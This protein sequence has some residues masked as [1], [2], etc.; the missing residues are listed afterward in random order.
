[1]NKMQA[2]KELQRV[3]KEDLEKIIYMIEESK[4]DYNSLDDFKL[5][6]FEE[7]ENMQEYIKDFFFHNYYIYIDYVSGKLYFRE[8]NP[9]VPLDKIFRRLD[10]ETTKT[11]LQ[12][13]QELKE[14]IKKEEIKQNKKLDDY[15]KKL[16]EEFEGSKTMTKKTYTPK[17]IT[18]MWADNDNQFL[19]IEFNNA[20]ILRVNYRDLPNDEILYTDD[21]P[22]KED[23][24]KMIEEGEWQ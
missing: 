18:G 17:E 14:I 20:K 23:L 10:C 19:E 7:M 8:F 12:D 13:Y 15:F 22:T 9:S 24:K 6:I 21:V 3:Y 11:L 2:I 5:D 16:S 1:M 4:D